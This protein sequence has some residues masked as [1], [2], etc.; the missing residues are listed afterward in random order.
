MNQSSFAEKVLERRRVPAA[1]SRR[2]ISVEQAEAIL[3]ETIDYVG[4]HED[5]VTYKYLLG[6]RKRLVET[7]V[8]IPCADKPDAAC[9]DVGCFGYMAFWA[10]RHLGYSRVE[11]IEFRPDL[12]AAKSARKLKVWDDDV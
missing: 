11:G 6:H 3:E 7:L 2:Y 4:R 9:L 1:A 8:R 12:K 10:W 5:A